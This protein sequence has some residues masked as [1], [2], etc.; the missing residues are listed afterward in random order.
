MNYDID[1]NALFDAVNFGVSLGTL[2]DA[3]IAL[4]QHTL[5]M[6][7]ERAEGKPHGETVWY[8]MELVR[9]DLIR[10]REQLKARA[11]AFGTEPILWVEN[12]R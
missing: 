5:I 7:Q 1:M 3:E 2:K 11:E 10:R 6:E 12:V 8:G 9:Q 4:I